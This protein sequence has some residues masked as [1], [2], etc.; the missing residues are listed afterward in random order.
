MGK[1]IA[2][3]LRCTRVRTVAGR[4]LCRSCYYTMRRRG[5]LSQYATT[6]QHPEHYLSQIDQSDS[7][8]CWPWPG[9]LNPA[10]Y[11]YAGSDKF[12][13]RWL[14]EQRIGPIPPG[15]VLDH[16]CHNRDLSC[17]GGDHC[18]H[19]RCVNPNH[20]AP[21]TSGENS[22]AS[23]VCP[24]TVNKAKGRCPAGHRYDEDNTYIAPTTGHRQCRKCRARHRANRSPK[25]RRAVRTS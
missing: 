21:K 12:A 7:E 2:A 14:Y 25:I 22:A 18:P 6:L 23:T 5:S 4:G 10:G 24:S 3:C 9:K 11:G 20:L 16:E 13:H 17:L 15:M 1:T 19:R 8:A